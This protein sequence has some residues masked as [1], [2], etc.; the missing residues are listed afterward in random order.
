M[1][2]S[3]VVSILRR[4]SEIGAGNKSLVATLRAVYGV[5]PRAFVDSDGEL[6]AGRLVRVTSRHLKCRFN[7]SDLEALGPDYWGTK[8]GQRVDRA[9]QAK[10]RRY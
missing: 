7:L 5:K 4:I 2:E 9:V 1:T 6:N 10:R 3:D 8:Q